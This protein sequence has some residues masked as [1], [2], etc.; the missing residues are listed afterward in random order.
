M[1]EQA[2]TSIVRIYRRQGERAWPIGC[3]FLANA[4][5]ILTCRHVISEALRPE[6]DLMGKEVELDFPFPHGSAL[7]KA[8]V[9]IVFEKPDLAKLELLSSL[10]E[11]ATPM[12]LSMD[13]DLWLHPYSAYGIT[14]QE[15]DGFWDNGEI[16]SSIADRTLQLESESVYKIEQGFSGTAV[17]DDEIKRAVGM[18]AKIDIDP[19]TK[20][21]KAA[22]AIPMA[23]ILEE[24]PELR[25]LA[26]T[27]QSK[28]PLPF[29]WN[30]PLQRNH[31]FTGR[32]DI[33]ADLALALRSGE[34]GDWKQALWGMGGVGKTQI[35][36]E[37]A[38]SH[39]PDYRVVW[40]LRSEEASTLLSD[41][42][43]MAPKLYPEFGPVGDVNATKDAVKAWIQ[44]NR[45]WLLIF[46]NAQNPEA[47]KDFLPGDG[48]GHVII[49]SR[50][51]EWG[52]L[53]KKFPIEVFKREESI[54]FI[55]DRT[56]QPDQEIADSLA[57]ELGDLPLALEQAVSYIEATSISLADYLDAFKKRR[58]ELWDQE[59]KP[60]DYP[61]TVATTWDLAM[62]EVIREPGAT[63]I[64]SLCAFLAPDEIPFEL[65]TEGKD[66]LSASLSTISNDNLAFNNALRTLRRYSLIESDGKT[67]SVHRLVQAVVRDRLG[68][69]KKD[70]AKTA[71]ALLSS[72][73]PFKVEDLATWDK[74][75]RLHPH[76]LVA[77]SHAEEL[78]VAYKETQHVLNEAGRYSRNRA[79]FL[80][81]KNQLERAL[82]LA[83]IVYGQ[84]HPEVATI[85]NNL[86]SVLQDMGELQKAREHFERALKIDELVYGPDH[87]GVAADVNN[88]GSVLQDIGELQK[89]QE[90]FERALKID[91]KIYGHDH[92]DVAIDAGNL[93][94][95]L[96]ALGDLEGAKNN[97][98]LALEIMVKAYDL[99][100]PH[101]ATALSDLGQVLQ[102]L[103]EL[104][105]ARECFERAL[106]IDE[107]IYDLDHPRVA[108]IV[109]NLGSVLQDMGELQKAREH[110]ER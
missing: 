78:E 90:C 84:N 17:W 80:G 103:G 101:I 100:H 75:E 56:R 61:D 13:M 47:I 107:K 16:K 58:A 82:I 25:P 19:Q 52:K 6:T 39:K 24:C 20:V 38:Y 105:K 40:W 46:D 9:I 83:E 45:G 99:N 37:Y 21:T 30:M 97:S 57:E 7:L 41:Y 79:D 68:E 67:L 51:Q 4:R 23:D 72:A 104:Q 65:L 66:A 27:T 96:R 54:N 42:A 94:K 64:L 31:N 89:A 59:E 43:Q 106:K 5:T 12:P 81:A 63:D 50:N 11:T 87:P 86:G 69:D 95:V 71:V 70:W 18:V 29:I 91:E 34:R 22:F 92:P 36:L 102:D 60:I 35:A 2:K 48:P 53:A 74:S 1:D 10:P 77:A 3:G 85:V 32:K 109:N 88:L 49:T 73:F 62:K 55:L 33:L 108:T 110:F 98:K 76:V 26:D 28:L 15:R 14:L 93:G 44:Q 8:R